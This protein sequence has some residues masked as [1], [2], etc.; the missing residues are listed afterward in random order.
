[1]PPKKK[2]TM[3]K[4]IKKNKKYALIPHRHFLSLIHNAGNKAAIRNCILDSGSKEDIV[5]LCNCIYNTLNGNVKL[6]KRSF[7][8]LKQY[9]DVMRYAIKPGLSFKRRKEALKQKGGF[10]PSLLL[11]VLGGLLLPALKK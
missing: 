4:A 3:K 11:N 1:M 2:P 5:C 8:K 7:M 10:L 9:K 6:D